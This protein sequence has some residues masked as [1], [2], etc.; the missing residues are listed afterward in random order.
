MERDAMK[1]TLGDGT[2]WGHPTDS[3]PVRDVCAR[4][5]YSYDGADYSNDVTVT[6]VKGWGPKDDMLLWI[7]PVD[8]DNVT[9]R[10]PGYWFCWLVLAGTFLV[11]FSQLPF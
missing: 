10:G 2:L 11:A 1:W 5:H 4:A 6:V 9:A 7:D 8:P 3:I